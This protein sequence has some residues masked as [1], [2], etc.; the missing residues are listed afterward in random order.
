LIR[1]TMATEPASPD[2]PNEDFVGATANGVVLLDGA[3]AAGL[4]T[5]CIHGVAWYA[6]QLGSQILGRLPGSR[7][8][9]VDIL[10]DSIRATASMHNVTC[11]LTHPG[12][13]SATV[14]IIRLTNDHLDYLVLADSTLV[15]VDADDA[16]CVVSDDREAQVGR[17]LRSRHI[18]SPFGTPAHV[19][20]L[21]RYIEDLRTHR[22]Q[23]GG[24]WVA[25]AEP[26]AAYEA[27]TASATG[28]RSAFL[29]SDGAA[30]LVDRF[31]L[32][33]WDDVVGIL[34]LQGPEE[35]VRR[36]RLAE[37]SDPDGARWPRAKINDDA[38]IAIIEHP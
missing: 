7:E 36:L 1:V 37:A 32:L 25:A 38:S 35:L 33:S 3:G 18:M 30:R 8:G 10:A 34:R 14:T 19:Q 31:Q 22:N 11:D 24:F 23:P 29:L 26:A 27:F 28:V 4:D 20:E 2:H 16:K 5:G 21:R 6:N 15:L 13:P 9:L 12:T 17:L